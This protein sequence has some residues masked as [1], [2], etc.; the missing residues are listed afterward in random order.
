M[1]P[2]I[3][4][5]ALATLLMVILLLIGARVVLFKWL[6]SPL[7]QAALPVE[8]TRA[9]TTEETLPEVSMWPVVVLLCVI[10]SLVVALM[11]FGNAIG[12]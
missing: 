3:P 6:K 10:V 12:G 8:T 4:I 7:E 1:M 2:H 9:R 5:T 11:V